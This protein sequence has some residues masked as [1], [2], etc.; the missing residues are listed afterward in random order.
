MRRYAS[1]SKCRSGWLQFGCIAKGTSIAFFY[2]VN[3]M[4]INMVT[5]PNNEQ[6]YPTLGDAWWSDEPGTEPV[7]EVRVS[8]LGDCRMEAMIAVHEIV[9]S[10]LCI[11]RGIS[12]A[13]VDAF[14]IEFEKAR[15][16]IGNY[17]H[18]GEDTGWFPF[19]GRSVNA[20]AEPGDD[21]EAPYRE[22]HCYATAVE[23]M[24]CAAMGISWDDYEKRCA[25]VGGEGR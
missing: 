21:I 12:I 20:D 18:T 23:R 5:I 6:R 3:S 24:L 8:A 7:L 14:D 16:V 9:E 25:S 15:E 19:R 10:V 11:N 2:K 4:K 17:P 1:K 13:A 22:Q